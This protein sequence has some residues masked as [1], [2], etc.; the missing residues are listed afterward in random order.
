M[1]PYL[2]LPGV[3]T[4]PEYL[5]RRYNAL[6]RILFAV[7]WGLFMLGRLSVIFVRAATMFQNLRGWEFWHSVVGTAVLV[8][9]T[10]PA[11]VCGRC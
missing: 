5:G 4:I 6:V 1:M 11:E 2:W 9:P 3:Y 10:R 7:A 8:G